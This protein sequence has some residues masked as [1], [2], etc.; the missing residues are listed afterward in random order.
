MSN[1]INSTSQNYGGK[2]SDITTNVKQ[3]IVGT[4]N[5]A[6]WIFRNIFIN[7]QQVFIKVL[8]PAINKTIGCEQIPVYIDSDLYVTGTI[9][10]TLFNPSDQILKD[11]IEKISE[12]KVQELKN[13]APKEFTYKEN[14][15]QKHYGFIA[16]DFEQIYPELVSN[17]VM[18]YKTINYL[19]LIP[20]LVSKI[21]SM[22]KE[23]D[24]L[25][26]HLIHLIHL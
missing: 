17:S 11:N 18:G 6:I 25:K 7:L 12:T 19:E 24:E 15:S 3:F 8:T 23:I 21:N 9:Y 13:L 5:P 26:I 14:P 2:V 20:L 1:F 4:R 16:Q 10:G 22:Q